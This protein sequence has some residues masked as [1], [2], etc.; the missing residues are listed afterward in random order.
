MKTRT[1]SVCLAA[2]VAAVF[3][4]PAVHAQ[5]ATAGGLDEIVVTARKTAERLQDVPLAITALTSED[6]EQRQIRDLADVAALT[7]GLNYESYLGGNGTPVIRGAAQGRI[8][9]LDQNVSTF[10]DGIYLPRQYVISPSLVGLERVEVVKGPQSAL[11]GRNA[12]MGAINYVTKKPGEELSGQ[13]EVTVGGDERRD[14]IAEISGALIPGKLYARLG[15]GKSDFDGDATNS[16]P[17]ASDAPDRGSPDKL[18]GWD[19]QAIQA[20]LVFRPIESLELD[21]GYYD[22][23]VFAE[24]PPIVRYQLTTNDMNCG[25]R[26]ANGRLPL[27]C[28]ELDYRFRPLPG[29]GPNAETVVDPR[30]FG[31]DMNSDLLRGHAEWS[32]TEA[33]TVVYEYGKLSAEA[34]GGG[35]SDRD[36]VLGSANIFAPTAPRGNQFQISP[37]GDLDY[38]SHEVRVQ[39]KPTPAVGLMLGYF[40]SELEDFDYFPLNAGLPLLGTAAFDI[41]QPGWFILSRG[42]TTVDASAV[43]GSASWQVNDRLRVA[44]EGRQ[45]KEEKTLVSGPTSFS[46]AVRTISGDWNTFT[47]RATVDFRLNEQSML[48]VTGAKGAKSGGFNLSALVPSQFEFQPDE[49]W[50]YEIGSKNTLLDGRLRLNAAVF[51]VDWK[52]QQVSC[53]ALGSPINI[54]PPAV[55]CNLGKAKIK[56]FETDVTWVPVDGLTLTAGFSYNDAKYADGVIDQRLRDFRFCDDVVCPRN[57]DIGGNQLMRQSKTQAS[58]GAEYEFPVGT[59]RAFAGG[60]AGYKS[61]Q[62]VDTVNLAYLPSRTIANLRAG[63]RGERFD[64]TVWAN[65][66]FDERYGSSAFAIFAATDVNYTPIQGQHRTWGVTGRYSFGGS[67]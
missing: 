66:A 15:Y 9:D 3:A 25:A 55:I 45:A 41:T 18:G 29:G 42:R 10:F 31:L 53:S 51:Y 20:R 39:Y 40:D 61:K 52:N 16:H 12:F 33:L 63:V 5:T 26:L 65:N 19:N 59:L 46:T 54:T 17:R 7:P 47:P 38:K 56:G 34:I 28:G 6:L 11:Y 50:T 30:G 21:I 62:Y 57:G 48:Y 22:F 43:F 32:P 67:R 60:D 13:A 23:E 1:G 8:Q 14:F 24:T 36:P 64:V 44:V 49:N 35:G 58:L 4:S 2:A 27:Y 37:A